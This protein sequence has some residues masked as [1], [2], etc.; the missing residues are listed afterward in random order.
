MIIKIRFVYGSL[1]FTFCHNITTFVSEYAFELARV[2]AANKAHTIQTKNCHLFDL[3]RQNLFEY[4][5]HIFR[6]FSILNNFFVVAVVYSR[7]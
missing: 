4:I 2:G 5:S 6:I 7:P 3:K 1:R